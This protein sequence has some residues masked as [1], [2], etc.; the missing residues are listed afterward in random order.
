[1]ATDYRSDWNTEFLESLEEHARSMTERTMTRIPGV[2]AKTA[3]VLATAENSDTVV[4]SVRSALEQ[5][6]ISP[7]FVE[8]YAKGPNVNWMTLVAYWQGVFEDVSGTIHDRVTDSLAEAL[9]AEELEQQGAAVELQYHVGRNFIDLRVKSDGSVNVMAVEDSKQGEVHKI[10]HTFEPVV[11]LA[12][13]F[14]AYGAA[15]SYKRN[16][17]KIRTEIRVG[18]KT[19]H[20]AAIATVNDFWTFNVRDRWHAFDLVHREG[21]FLLTANWPKADVERRAAMILSE[22]RKLHER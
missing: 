3:F 18:K 22:G 2:D 10:Q 8:A 19:M 6:V 20:S 9:Y 7:R 1:M 16:E 14:K 17:D 15:Y 21:A 11:S 5:G 13:D 12:I 4:E